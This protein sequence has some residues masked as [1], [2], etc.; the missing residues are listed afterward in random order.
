MNLLGKALTSINV[1]KTRQ[2][3]SYNVPPRSNSEHSIR[4]MRRALNLSPEL[5][6]ATTLPQ[7][8]RAARKLANA[9][10]MSVR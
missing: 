2:A 9:A 10:P 6:A 4:S 8:K 5:R 7:A 1:N 3:G